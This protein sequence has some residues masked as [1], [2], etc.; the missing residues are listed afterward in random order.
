MV[1]LG[2]AFACAVP[3]VHAHHSFRRQLFLSQLC[4]NARVGIKSRSTGVIKSVSR[5]CYESTIAMTEK[6]NN[7][8]ITFVTGNKNKLKEVN[9]ILGADEPGALRIVSQKV[10]LPELQGEPVDI[11]R[12]KC[13][14]AGKAIKGPVLVED[15][16][17]CFNAL[18]G[19]P[20]PYI[21][22][23]L[24]KC[25]H[26]G[27][28]QL[29]VGFED[30]SGYALCT[31]AYSTGEPDF[32]PLVFEGRTDGIIVPA[33]GPTD[34]GWDPIFQPN[35][36]KETYAEM[37]KSVKNTISHRYRALDAFKRYLLSR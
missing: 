13:K 20:G 23:F 1:Y 8:T 22:W 19:L 15:T 34:F 9:S 17:L 4:S 11:A 33:R 25:G 3:R 36:F 6:G 21:K 24:D 30:K 12:E 35:G 28:N 5:P 32:E 29:L 10:D 16:C 27:L 31:F 2:S 14:L 7:T 18:K 37:H 26:K